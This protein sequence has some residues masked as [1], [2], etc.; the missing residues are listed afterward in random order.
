[1]ADDQD[2]DSKTEEATPQRLRK[3]AEDGQFGYSSELVSGLMLTVAAAMAIGFG[4]LFFASLAG[5]IKFRLTYFEPMIVDSRQLVP[6]FIDDLFSFG[7]LILGLILPVM[8][9]AAVCGVLQ[10][11][12]NVSMKPLELKWD[13]LSVRKGFGRIFSGRSVARGVFAILKVCLILLLTI[14]VARSR[15][16][17]ITFAGFSSYYAMMVTLGQ[18]LAYTSLVVGACMLILGVMDLAYQRYKHLRDLRMSIQDVKDEQKDTE[19]DPLIRARVKRLQAELGK[20]RMLADVTDATAVV[21]NPTHYAVAIKYDRA[22]MDAP[23]VVAKGADH[24]AKKIIEIAKLNDVPVVERKPV[25]RFLF[26]NVDIG[27]AVPI[28]IYQ[29]VAEILNFVNRMRGNRSPY[30]R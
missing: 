4:G 5:L 3:A 13:K 8:L 28:E 21:T 24:L 14:L 6:A 20:K 29:A 30:H 25:A 2:R 11:N 12:F 23:I 19:G 22:T 10:T 1:M 15:R 18:I 17:Q 16:D 26:A 27:R 7:L 9:A